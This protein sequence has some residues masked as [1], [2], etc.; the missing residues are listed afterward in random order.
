MTTAMTTPIEQLR[1][2][3]RHPDRGPRR[4]RRLAS[5]GCACPASTP[6]RASP[7]CSATPSNGRWRIAPGRRAAGPPG[8]ATATARSCSRPSATPPRAPS[9]SSTAC[10]SATSSVDVV[11]IVEGVSGRV[12][13]RMDLVVRF[14]YGSIVPVGAHASTAAHR[15]SIAGPD[16]AAPAHAGARSSGHDYRHTAEF[17]VGRGRPG[18]VRAHLATRRIEPPPRRVDA[19]AALDRTDRV[20]AAS[21]RPVDVRRRVARR[22]ACA[23]SITLKA[24][25]YAPTGG[26]VAAPTTS[27]PEWIGGVRNWDYRYCWL[28]DATFTLYSLMTAGYTDEALRVGATGCCARWPAIPPHLQIMY[29]PAGERRLDRVRG[30]LAARLR[31]LDAG[32]GRQRRPPTSSSSTCTARCSTRC[33]RRRRIGH[34]GGPERVGAAAGDPRLPRVGLAASPTRA[35]GRCAAAAPPLHPLEGDGVGGVRPRGEGRSRSSGS[36]GPVDRWRA[37]PRRD[38]RTRSCDRGLRRRAQRLRAV[39]RLEGPR[40]QRC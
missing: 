6:A 40:R 29:G 3:R 32:A 31:G 35:S 2:H 4:R 18:A 30:R 17:T 20:L 28:R 19:V 16:G 39:L 24:L 25:T 22:G 38:P 7:R 13:M 36:T 9:A 23:R 15:R 34:R 26:I 12:P 8:A 1:A 14:D 21:G 5:T 33:T 27:L 11:R 10:R 37:L